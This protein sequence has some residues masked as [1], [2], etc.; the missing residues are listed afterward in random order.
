MINSSSKTLKHIHDHAN[1]NFGWRDVFS[2]HFKY[3]FFF[4]NRKYNFD[5]FEICLISISIMAVRSLPF[6][7]SRG[8]VTYAIVLSLFVMYYNQASVLSLVRVHQGIHTIEF[9][10]CLNRIFPSISNN[11]NLS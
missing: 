7:F 9:C 5:R 8:C 6:V 11:E 2:V 10:A 3:C 4:F 1:T